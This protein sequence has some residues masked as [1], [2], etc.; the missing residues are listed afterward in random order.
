M[1]R[2]A[3]AKKK[4]PSTPAAA[5]TAQAGPAAAGAVLLDF[6]QRFDAGD[7]AGARRLAQAAL[8]ANASGDTADR[9]R[10]LLHKA[11]L[12]G[13]P[14]VVFGALLVVLTV[15]FFTLIVG[16][17][18]ELQNAPPAVDLNKAAI[19]VAPAMPVPASEPGVQ[20]PQPA[21][22]PAPQPVPAT[23]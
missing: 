12:D 17:N 6:E 8:Q 9:A 20:D 23:P 19:R 10:A 4:K 21:A 22:A 14:F 15:V 5:A 18:A 3:M 16:R 2:A 1:V 11:D 13:P 7:A